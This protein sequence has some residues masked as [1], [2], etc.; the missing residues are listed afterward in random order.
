[1]AL[2]VLALVA[3]VALFFS[4]RLPDAPMTTSPGRDAPR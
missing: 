1:M 4:R 2:G 3:L